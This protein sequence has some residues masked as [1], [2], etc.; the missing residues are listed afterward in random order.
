[1]VA[2]RLAVTHFFNE[3]RRGVVSKSGYHYI[4]FDKVLHILIHS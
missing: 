1:M 2:L 3:K 4:L